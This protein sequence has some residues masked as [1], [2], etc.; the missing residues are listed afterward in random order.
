M[1][2]TFQAFDVG[3]IFAG[4]ASSVVHADAREHR[5]SGLATERTLGPCFVPCL[6]LHATHFGH[7]IGKITLAASDEQWRMN[8]ATRSLVLQVPQP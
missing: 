2:G 8:H 7:G 4:V 1:N 3:C 6:D 5:R